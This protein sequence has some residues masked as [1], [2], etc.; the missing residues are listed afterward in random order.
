MRKISLNEAKSLVRELVE[1]KEFPESE[2]A[3]FQ[4]LLWAFVELGEATDAFKKGRDWDVIVE[5]LMDT[6]FYILDFVGLVEK[7]QQIQLDLDDI[8]LKKWEKNLQRPNHFGL[9]KDLPYSLA[10][11]PKP[12]K[13]LT[14]EIVKKCHNK[15]VYCSAYVSEEDAERV[16]SEKNAKQI[17]DQYL[18]LGGQE[19]NISGGEP[20]LHPKWYDIAT[21]AK[22]KGLKVRLFSCGILSEKYVEDTELSETIDRIVKTGFDSVEMTLHAPYSTMHDEITKVEGSFKNTYRFI[23]LLSSKIDNLEV[24]FVPMQINADELEE[25]VDFVVG[26][27]IKRLNILRFIPQ[28]R[29]LVNKDWLSLKKDQLSRLVRVALSLSKRSD[30]DVNI[31]H[32]GDFTFLL[33]KSRVPK[34]CTAGIEQC[35]VKINGDVVPCPAFGDLK[36]WVAG[37][38]FRQRLEE[39]WTNSPILVALREFDHMR[40]QGQCK[41]C[42]HLSI[43]QGRCPAERI[44]ANGALY[45]GPDPGCPK[46]YIRN[47]QTG[48]E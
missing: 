44:R 23:K 3:L 34:L 32:P 47:T 31:G 39:I 19:L 35:M 8:F 40:M 5:E 41:L 45:R 36:E 43:C 38:V 1:K 14:I 9:R 13:K 42:E 2:A 25:L 37:N 4:K 21:Y 29:G 18:L 46:N 11:V 26:L 7:T 10:I 48:S 15:C 20:L 6:V 30:I 22:S 24:N 33:D 12:P 27:G 17:I 16:L 28:G